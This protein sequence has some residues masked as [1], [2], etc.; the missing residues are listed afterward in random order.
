MRHP[1][2]ELRPENARAVAQI[3]ARLEGIPLAIE[4]AAA[5][6]GLLSAEQIAGRL[7]HS[8]KLLA[9]GERT[10]DHRHRTLRATL[11]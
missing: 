4:L 11:D 2:F 3:C 9:G 8:P 1:D 10:T 6:I 7:G 5:R